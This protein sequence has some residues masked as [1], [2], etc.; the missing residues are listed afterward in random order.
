MLIVSHWDRGYWGSKGFNGGRGEHSQPFGF[1]YIMF[2]M[3]IGHAA[4]DVQV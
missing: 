3:T 1:V 2:E 4:E